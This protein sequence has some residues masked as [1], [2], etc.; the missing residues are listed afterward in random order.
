MNQQQESY[1]RSHLSNR[2]GIVVSMHNSATQCA[3]PQ[4]SKELVYLREGTLNLLE[5]ESHSDDQS[6]S[7]VGAF[8]IRSV[9]SKFFWLCGECTKTLILKRWTTAGLV[10]VHR[11]QKTAGNHPNLA[12][13]PATNTTTRPIPMPRPVPRMSPGQVTA[14]ACLLQ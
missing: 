13:R 11:N 12:A 2:P 8:A 7:D 14:T 10:L 5:L 4:C 9:P 6:Q 3:N 1:V